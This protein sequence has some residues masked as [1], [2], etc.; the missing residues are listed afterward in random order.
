MIFAWIAALLVVL[1]AALFVASAVGS[2]RFRGMYEAEKAELT[3][4]ANATTRAK[5]GASALAGLPEPVR[6][7]VAVTR[8][9]NAQRPRVATLAQRGSL[10][11]S[12]GG[13]FMPFESEQVYSFDPPGFVWFARAQ[14][15][16]LIA[17]Y[18]RDEFVDGRGNM[19]IR[20][21]GAFTVADGRGREMDLGAGLRFWGE[22]IAFPE[23]VLDPHLR[24]TPIG[25]QE[26]GLTV[27]QGVL[28]MQARVVFSDQ[29]FPVAIHAERYRDVDGTP[30]LTRWSGHSRDWQQI[31][32]RMFPT[33]WES[34]WHLPDGDFSAVKME[35]LSVRTD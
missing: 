4:R 33:S 20:L 14:L 27:E 29:G 1:I 6:K 25:E 21:L 15:A 28:K 16:P 3:R 2:S 31:D 23:I 30:V 26:V 17:M 34:V 22:A 10:R 12:P 11:A 24:W 13:S 7:Y 32:G 19:L 8:S 35:V 9:Q 5:A 18:A